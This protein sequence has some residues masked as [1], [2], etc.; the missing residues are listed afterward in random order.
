L[1]TQE[2]QN[3]PLLILIYELI[4]EGVAD[5]LAFFEAR[6]E[7]PDPWLFPHIVRHRICRRLDELKDTNIS[8][9][10]VEL[11]NSGVEIRLDNQRIRVFKSTPDGELPAPG[12]S[13]ARQ[14]FYNRNLFGSDE[15]V[16]GTANLVVM[17][18]VDATCNLMAVQLVCPK[19]DGPIYKPGQQR[20][21]VTIPHP[22]TTHSSASNL[23]DG[24]DLNLAG[25]DQDNEDLEIEEEGG[26]GE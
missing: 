2:N 9:E 16:F 23:A 1:I 21:A 15:E 4:E 12:R 19:Q 11:P 14:D 5:A 17:W 3:D 13:R 7:S 18:E 20:W 6:G 8:Y 24:T 26:T 25:I 22:A 10:R